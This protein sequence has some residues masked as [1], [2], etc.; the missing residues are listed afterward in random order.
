M[1]SAPGQ[2]LRV[3]LRLGHAGEIHNAVET[4][5]VLRNMT[6]LHRAR[7]ARIVNPHVAQPSAGHLGGIEQGRHHV[8]SD[9]VGTADEALLRLVGRGAQEPLVVSGMEDRQRGRRRLCL[10]GGRQHVSL[11]P[12]LGRHELQCFDR[13][14]GAR[15]PGDNL[16]EQIEPFCDRVGV[17]ELGRDFNGRK[18]RVEPI[19][20][21]HQ[22]H[23]A[24]VAIV[25][26]QE[27]RVALDRVPLDQ[28]IPSGPSGSGQP[29]IEFLHGRGVFGAIKG[30]P[31][32]EVAFHAALARIFKC[33][34]DAFAAFSALFVGLRRNECRQDEYVGLGGADNLLEPLQMLLGTDDEVSGIK[35]RL[36]GQGTL[37]RRCRGLR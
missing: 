13:P 18:R 21:A 20:G 37:R 24:I 14:T 23:R 8:R 16:A 19:A 27:L 26:S 9:L 7:A 29:Q 22:H 4:L 11:S 30:G 10:L 28:E 32:E 36:D 25:G 5:A 15:E 1:I 31:E 2:K 35:A 17:S 34:H 3:Q 6:A 33:S 12:Q